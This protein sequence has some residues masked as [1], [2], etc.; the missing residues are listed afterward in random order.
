MELRPRASL[1]LRPFIPKFHYW[2]H[3]EEAHEQYSFNYGDGAGHSDGEAIE[4]V[5]SAHNALA[6]STKVSGPGT[7]HDILDDNFG[8]WN[9]LKYISMGGFNL[10]P[11]FSSS[12][13]HYNLLQE[14]P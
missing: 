4:R 2:A 7:R 9:Y 10:L 8:Y 5:W 1:H 12:N 6:G 3:K 13:L 14:T 11:Y